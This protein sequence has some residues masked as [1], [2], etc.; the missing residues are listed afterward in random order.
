MSRYSDWYA[1]ELDGYLRGR[2]SEVQ[3]FEST[4]E[5]LNH[6]SEHVEDL[7]AKGMNSVE[8]EK[9]AIVAFGPPRQAALNLISSSKETM[10]GKWLSL[11]GCLC[12]AWLTF[13]LGLNGML[14]Q[15]H[16]YFQSSFFPLFYAD[17][18]YVIGI[19]VLS[20][21]GGV[22]LTRK[23]PVAKMLLAGGFGIASIGILFLV[24]P[25][26]NYGNVPK[27]KFDSMATKWRS[28]H[29]VTKKLAALE[30]SICEATY[31]QRYSGD[32]YVLPISDL[33]M[34]SIN[35]DTPKMVALNSEYIKIAG[36][37]IG[38]YLG[39]PTVDPT[40]RW[41]NEDDDGIDPRTFS[42]ETGDMFPVAMRTF[43]YYDTPQA[44]LRA[45]TDSQQRYGSGY[46]AFGYAARDQEEFIASAEKF[47]KLSRPQLLAATILP[48]I[49][50]VY[51]YLA[52]MMLV[53][54][55][56]TKLPNMTLRTSFR[57]RFA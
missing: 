16:A 50:I 1:V 49:L 26:L 24:G 46:S 52:V 10:A 31:A 9:A 56:L 42:S 2:M 8:A 32:K 12:I 4:K 33:A 18:R 34:K 48:V 57:R 40:K 37:R 28:A 51:T 55:P 30:N 47:G 15:I 17:M 29:E 7:V 45:W 41:T 23:V 43:H 36:T 21:I 25:E 22:I 53:A 5:I 20:L 6:F 11:I 54:W 19:L 39:P 44:A 27:N 38:G 35:S 3:R 14:Y 13:G